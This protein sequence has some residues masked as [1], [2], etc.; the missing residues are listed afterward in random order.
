MDVADLC[1]FV[2]IVE[3]GNL[4][5]AARRLTMTRAN[6]SLRLARL[7]RATATQL[8]RRTTRRVEPTEA[9]LRLYQHGVQ[10]RNELQAAQDSMATLTGSF[11]GR[12]RV[13]VPV[14]FGQI[15]MTSWFIAFK[16]LYPRVALD[17][18]FDSRIGDDLLRDDVDFGVRVLDEP[19]ASLVAKKL[20]DLRY[21]A[22]ASPQFAATT[23]LPTRVEDLRRVPVITSTVSNRHVPL[24]AVRHG[25]HTEIL[26]EPTVSSENSV[27][28]RELVAAGIGIGILADYTIQSELDA[29]R[30]ITCLDDYRLSIARAQ[31]YLVYMPNRRHTRAASAF[32]EFIL[33]MEKGRAAASARAGVSPVP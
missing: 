24:S 18:T 12:L 2:E 31:R 11:E 21:V 9:G 25:Q 7:E 14:G 27:F 19:P 23:S 6:V 33:K 26:L 1:L 22:C 32:I 17:I 15:V 10:I 13:A 3:A 4:S 8:L 30:L 20:G 28:L 29:G 16:K 5:G